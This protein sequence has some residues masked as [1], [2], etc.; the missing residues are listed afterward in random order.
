MQNLI[1]R[2]LN[3]QHVETVQQDGLQVKVETLNDG[4]TRLIF[5]EGIR[6]VQ[7]PGRASVVRGKLS[8]GMEFVSVATESSS[9]LK[10]QVVRRDGA[11]LVGS[12][13]ECIPGVG[14][15]KLKL[16]F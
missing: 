15:G 9:G 16:L 5:S 10:V 4:G 8:D 3:P 14:R 7:R 2:L 13:K 11:V 6:A 1:D 12:S